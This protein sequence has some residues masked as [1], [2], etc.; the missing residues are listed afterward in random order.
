M[1]RALACD[2]G[3]LAWHDTILPVAVQRAREA[4]LRVILVTSRTFFD[5][6]RV[7]APLELFDAAVAENGAV[8]YYPREGMIRDQAPPPPA[9]L[10]AEL[11]RRGIL[12]QRG[13]VIVA[14]A[15]ADERRIREALA[16]VHVSRELVHDQA[17][18]SL[19]PAGVS[20]GAGVRQVLQTFGLSPHDVL[21]VGGGDNEAGLFEACGWAGCPEDA[22][23]DLRARADWVFPGV[24]GEAITR[25]IV[26]PILGDRLEC[27]RSARHRVMLGWAAG[28]AAEVSI[29]ERGVNVLI[30][31]EPLSG[32]SWLAGAIVER[33][34]RRHYAVCVIDPEG[35]YRVLREVPGVSWAEIPCGA[36]LD[37]AFRQ[38]HG[39]P[40]GS[41]VLDFSTVPHPR[42]VELVGR[43]LEL[44][45]ASR[46]L[47]GRPHWVVL[48]EAHYF[49][50]GESSPDPLIDMGAKGYC[51]VTYRPSWLRRSALAMI[52][53][54]LLA[55][56]TGPGELAWLRSELAAPGPGPDAAAAAADLPGGEFL[57]VET[58][59]A[60]AASALTF[61]AAPRETMHVRHLWK[62]LDSRVPD[63]RSFLFRETDGRVVGSADSLGEFRR[64]LHRVGDQ[65]VGEHA[66]RG[67]FS[68]WIR[69][70]FA[71]DELARSVAKAEGRWR[72]GEMSDLR[73]TIIGAIGARYG[74][75]KG[76]AV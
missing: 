49:L 75:E 18:L 71:D 32:K 5:L 55:R 11:D 43:A 36:A 2:D 41:T 14:A 29:P 31:G 54:L 10:L 48:D 74:P 58:G 17:A 9:Q 68:R 66:E 73:S 21:A 27:A 47:F 16:A 33:L 72:R 34:V 23:P 42:K 26:G 63:G 30:Q 70:V 24:D 28:T 53:I 69:D 76:D 60:G 59:P 35:D 8:L 15:R 38:L 39:D 51:L 25:A 6:T 22:R 46:A 13:R 64:T 67:D 50:H 44:V 3:T 20:K 7:C 52:D 45:R 12:Y 4:G 19:L 57:L 56:T 62:Y 1:F 40:T 37:R 65:V 61:T